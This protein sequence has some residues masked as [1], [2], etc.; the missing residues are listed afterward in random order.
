M[1]DTTRI[2][3]G[4]L[5]TFI[6]ENITNKVQNTT[7]CIDIVDVKN[8][9]VQ[10]NDNIDKLN[11]QDVKRV[12]FLPSNLSDI[13][14]LYDIKFFHAGVLSKCSDKDKYDVSLYASVISCLKHSFLAQPSQY[15]ANFLEKF[16]HR[17][18]SE[19]KTKFDTFEYKK[20]KWNKSELFSD[21][22]DNVLGKNVVKYLSDYF[23]INI[24]ILDLEEDEL[25]FSNGIEF[26]P[27]KKNVFIL[28]H[29]D[30]TFEPFYTEY[31][32]TFGL[33]DVTLKK[34]M[35]N[36][37]LLVPFNL[38]N[39]ID[40]DVKI[41]EDDL[42]KYKTKVKDTFQ[43][44]SKT[45]MI[46]DIEQENTVKVQQ[47][48]SPVIKNVDSANGFG[49]D[50]DDDDDDDDDDKSASESSE[51]IETG[52]KPVK[53]VIKSKSKSNCSKSEDNNDDSDDSNSDDSNSDD[54]NSDDS[55]SDDD[56][57][58]SDSDS[59]VS[60]SSDS[61]AESNESDKPKTKATPAINTKLD[62]TKS[63]TKAKV[64]TVANI[65]KIKQNNSLPRATPVM[66]ITELKKMASMVGV[67]V[68]HKVD[69]KNV[70]K[71]KTQL[72]ADINKANK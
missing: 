55:N 48:A 3:I 15:Q 38:M 35:K 9:T 40:V 69:G 54:S 4:T 24:F 5:L 25:H 56:S 57:D 26:V 41:V 20:F 71:N 8:K 1:D 60:S 67:N 17:F 39:S 10:Q 45:H 2:T 7:D 33:A 42:T 6:K 49:E 30:N 50:S 59:N 29:P 32:K 44:I 52:N 27:Y 62:K 31:S 28:R 65:G 72:V 19:A 46:K 11:F 22:N 43:K 63:G 51:I 37:D 66:T 18:K 68:T 64:E 70:A 12:T 53:K 14:D 16:L 13:F 58:D 23:H 36:L 21:I 47:K 34:I 61:S